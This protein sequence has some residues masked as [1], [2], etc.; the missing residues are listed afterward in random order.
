AADPQQGERARFDD[1]GP[2]VVFELVADPGELELATVHANRAIEIEDVAIDILVPVEE[3][4]L[5]AAPER[6]PKADRPRIAGVIE[7]PAQRRPRPHRRTDAPRMVATS[8]P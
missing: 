5:I 3:A 1:R 2:R 4:D 8:A 7:G 6:D